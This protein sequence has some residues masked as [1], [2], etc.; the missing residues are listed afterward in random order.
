VSFLWVFGPFEKLVFQLERDRNMKMT[1]N[2]LMVI[3]VILFAGFTVAYATFGQVLPGPP[4][5]AGDANLD[6]VVSAG[7]YASVQATFGDTIAPGPD[8]FPLIGDANNDGVVSAGDY[9]CIQANFG[10]TGDPNGFLLGDANGDGVVSAGD[11]AAVM[12]GFGFPLSP[13]LGDANRDG[14]VSAGD[15]ASVQANFGNVRSDTAPA[16]EPVTM[17]MLCIGGTA[18]LR[19]RRWG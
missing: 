15:Y 8:D 9:A 5:L 17:A 2:I 19:R 18:L 12:T 14:V 13:I 11:Y 1:T 16:P 6:S 7:D 4:P 3:G 10:N